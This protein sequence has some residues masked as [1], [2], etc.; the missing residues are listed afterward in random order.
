[1]YGYCMHS[2]LCML[3]VCLVIVHNEECMYVDYCIVIVIVCMVNMCM[4]VYV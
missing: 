2:D 1:M 4:V 3:V